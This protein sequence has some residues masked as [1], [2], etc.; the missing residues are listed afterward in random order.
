MRTSSRTIV[1]AT[2]VSP[3]P[4]NSGERLRAVNL[5]TALRYLGYEVHAFVGNYNSVDLS[6]FNGDGLTYRQIPFAWPRLRQETALYIR[7]HMGF[8]GELRRLDRQSHIRA[9]ILDYGFLGAQ[10]SPL[11]HAGI[12]VLL[13]TH[14]VESVLTGQAPMTSPLSALAIQLRQAIE[15]MHERWFFP[16][17]N[18]VLCV[19]EADCREYAKF[20][21]A[22]RLHII[23]N[24]VDIPDR[25]GNIPKLDRVIM[26]G[27]F[28]NFQNREGLR[29]FLENVWDR[30]LASK[31]E[32]CIAGKGSREVAE[33][34]FD[35]PRLTSL[36]SCDDL[37][38]EIAR[39]RCA[40]VPL[41]RG[42]GTRF[43]CLEAMGVRT[44]VV[45]TSKGCEGIEHEGNFIVADTPEGFRAS[46]L[47]ILED[48]EGAYDRAIAARRVFDRR[49]SLEAN[50]ARLE[51]AIASAIRDGEVN[52]GAQAT[53]RRVAAQQSGH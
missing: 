36:G 19:S 3:F 47:S 27:S 14:N 33:A 29:W 53:Q 40:I 25:Y 20:I 16:K 44:P 5:I 18:A 4:T 42:G 30:T 38:T 15:Q 21:P 6:S 41:W 46:I 39:A 51:Y 52:G 45:T 12:P 2:Y 31:A 48:A 32:L 22:R 9:V 17:A 7:P 23:P 8:I 50:A 35:T 26:S 1:Y 11:R 34:F 28:D 49:Y 13:G 24:F 10:I 43:K 37:L